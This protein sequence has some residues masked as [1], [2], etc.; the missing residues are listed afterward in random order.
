MTALLEAYRAIQVFL[1]TGGDVLFAIML[2]TFVLWALIIE[3]VYYNT[4]Q[5]RRVFNDAV[6][7]W[8]ARKDKKSWY[9]HQFR[10]LLISEAK[11]K[12]EQNIAF[13]K[14]MVAVAP[15]L[16]LLGTVTGMV[17]VFDAMAVLGTGNPRAMAS[18]VSQ[19][20][21]PTMSG[22]VVAISGLYFSYML[23]RRADREVERLSDT[24]VMEQ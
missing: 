16:G 3:R 5:H 8:E 1:E 22:M 20:T 21:I 4:F 7:R 13:I 6:A 9:G 15:L 2:V 23:R 17:A 10:N 24:L 12:I 14:T 11:L 19:A 18:G